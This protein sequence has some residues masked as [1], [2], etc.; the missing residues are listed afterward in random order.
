MLSSTLLYFN[1]FLLL[2]QSSPQDINNLLTKLEDGLNKRK[3]LFNESIQRYSRFDY[4]LKCLTDRINTILKSHGKSINRYIVNKV[5]PAI[6]S[7]YG[8]H[9][10]N[11]EEKWTNQIQKLEKIWRKRAF[12]FTSEKCSKLAYGCPDVIKYHTREIDHR[13]A[14][15]GDV[16]IHLFDLTAV[17]DVYLKV[18]ALKKTHEGHWQ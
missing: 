5:I 13:Q 14:H 7:E 11:E 12:K 9:L 4:R 6:R 2:V 3:R 10:T 17:F 16:Y 15:L 18:L 1:V 8:D